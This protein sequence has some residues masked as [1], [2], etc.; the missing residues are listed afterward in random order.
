M[1]DLCSKRANPAALQRDMP[2]PCDQGDR[3]E[4]SSDWLALINHH[5]TNGGG[6]IPAGSAH[7]TV[8][9]LWFSSLRVR[10]NA[11]GRAR[12]VAR[13][14]EAD[15]SG[16]RSAGPSSGPVIDVLFD[17]VNSCRTGTRT[18]RRT[19]GRELIAVSVGPQVVGVALAIVIGVI[20]V[21]G[22]A[23]SPRPSM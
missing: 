14:D 4:Q 1:Q 10:Q 17:I 12:P 18:S 9:M 19:A 20:G 6:V 21:I 23:G 16:E 22:A 15:G 11:S 2:L 7:G 13:L 5:S 3:T 8:G